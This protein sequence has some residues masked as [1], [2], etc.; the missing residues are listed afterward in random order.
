[1]EKDKF[2]T[3][4]LRRVENALKRKG[5]IRAKKYGLKK[6]PTKMQGQI[7][8]YVYITSGDVFQKDIEAEFG[9]RRPT[10]SEILSKME[11]NGLIHR[12]SVDFD[13]RLKK[14]TLTKISVDIIEDIKNEHKQ[15]EARVT[16][17]LTANEIE[18]FEKVLEK[19]ETNILNF[20]E[21]E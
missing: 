11:A 17:G 13:A 12:T 20:S 15:F 10:A 14:I 18:L 2:L 21:E 16:K 6:P 1:M 5:N 9:L 3:N 4:K 19:I 8:E 7:L